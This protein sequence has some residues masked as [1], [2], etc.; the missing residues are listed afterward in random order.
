MGRI[1]LFIRHE[2]GSLPC[3]SMVCK[4]SL[5]Q[6][7][8]KRHV[9]RQSVSLFRCLSD[10]SRGAYNPGHGSNAPPSLKGSLLLVTQP[11]SNQGSTIV[12]HFSMKPKQCIGGLSPEEIQ[13]LEQ[14]TE[15]RLHTCVVCGRRN[16]YAIRDSL[17][18]WVPEPHDE[19]VPRG[20]HA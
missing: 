1:S 15:L 4:S 13:Q 11:V 7:V 9:L 3:F 8:P 14:E 20:E 12:P 5:S 2:K 6:A 19:P 10:Q 18:K 17:G 16:L